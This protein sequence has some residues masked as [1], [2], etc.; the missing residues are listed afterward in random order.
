MSTPITTCPDLGCSLV[1]A[2][3][4]QLGPFG[5]GQQIRPVTLVCL[6]LAD[7]SA[8]GLLVDAQVL[9]DMSDRTA[10]GLDFADG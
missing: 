4:A 9:R 8:Q 2:E 7:P 5:G 1:L 10:G 3:L 6:G